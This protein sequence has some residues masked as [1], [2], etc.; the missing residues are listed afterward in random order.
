MAVLVPEVV[1]RDSE[2]D[3]GQIVDPPFAVYTITRYRIAM[4]RGR[5]HLGHAAVRADGDRNL[6]A[7]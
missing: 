6:R 7:R 5:I 2:F 4:F 1:P 3:H